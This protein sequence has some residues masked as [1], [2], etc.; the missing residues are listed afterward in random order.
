VDLDHGL[1]ARCVPRFDL[2]Q[3]RTPADVFSN[4]S[5]PCRRQRPAEER[6]QADQQSLLVRDYP[7]RRLDTLAALTATLCRLN[8]SCLTGRSANSCIS[9]F[10][11]IHPSRRFCS[12]RLPLCHLMRLFVL[13]RQHP[14][15]RWPTEVRTHGR[16]RR[17]L[18]EL[19]RRLSDRQPY[20]PGPTA[21]AGLATLISL[22]ATQPHRDSIL[23]RS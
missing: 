1:Y 6:R 15:V 19:R 8:P 3:P 20:L 5:C 4:I 9:R 12:P 10:H 23:L 16:R 14:R 21:R 7:V 18:R 13:R 2:L 22:L 11:C 17:P